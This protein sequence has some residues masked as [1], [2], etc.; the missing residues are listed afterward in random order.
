MRSVAC[1][2]HELRFS[3]TYG[4]ENIVAA[5]KYLVGWLKAFFDYVVRAAKGDFE[6]R[7]W[8]AIMII[9]RAGKACEARNDFAVKLNLVAVAITRLN[10][11]KC[12]HGSMSFVAIGFDGGR[13]VEDIIII[14]TCNCVADTNKRWYISLHPNLG[15]SHVDVRDHGAID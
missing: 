5:A 14:I 1:P 7:G 15:L 9:S 4:A 6:I 11:V 8:A 3:L 13:P 12:E 10:L 2:N